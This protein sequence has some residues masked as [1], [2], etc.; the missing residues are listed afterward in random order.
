MKGN[1]NSDV[2]NNQSESDGDVKAA[3][4]GLISIFKNKLFV[5][6][7]PAAIQAFK[8]L[9]SHLSA[10]YALY[11]SFDIGPTASYVKQDVRQYLIILISNRKIKEKILNIYFI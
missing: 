4:D 7:F 8:I 10:H 9:S 2:I 11:D 3:V 1:S 6:P 5:P